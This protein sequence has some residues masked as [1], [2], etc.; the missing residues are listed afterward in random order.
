MQQLEFI[1]L[2][3]VALPY[4]LYYVGGIIAIGQEAKEEREA[5]EKRKKDEGERR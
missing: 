2:S 5:K 1:L 3:C 4:I